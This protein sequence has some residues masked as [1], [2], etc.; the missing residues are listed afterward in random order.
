MSAL[1]RAVENRQVEAITTLR[2]YN[3]DV[4]SK[5]KIYLYGLPDV[6]PLEV[7]T[8]NG[9]A[10]PAEDLISY[11]AYLRIYKNF[12]VTRSR[13]TNLNGNGQMATKLAVDDKP[14]SKAFKE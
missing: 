6:T 11:G 2:K 7:S 10:G 8:K 4:M 3:A 9:A 13:R 12:L 1:H 5:A 14:V